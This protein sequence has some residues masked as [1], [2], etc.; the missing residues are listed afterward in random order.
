M[1]FGLLQLGDEGLAHTQK[2][3]SSFL[4]EFKLWCAAPQQEI[5]EIIGQLSLPNR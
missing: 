2:V 1:G 3:M 4:R 5:L